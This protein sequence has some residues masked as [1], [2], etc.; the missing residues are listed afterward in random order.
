MFV[1]AYMF[2]YEKTALWHDYG[3]LACDKC[4]WLADSLAPCVSL[5]TWRDTGLSCA[6]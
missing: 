6:L 4:L 1:S 3:F 2:G 5:V